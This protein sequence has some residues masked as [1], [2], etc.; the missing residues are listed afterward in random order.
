M[1]PSCWKLKKKSK[2][3]VDERTS[4]NIHGICQGRIVG[5]YIERVEHM[6]IDACGQVD[7]KHGMQR[8]LHFT[9]KFRLNKSRFS[10]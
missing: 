8:L 6:C 7:D 10:I 9:H 3:Q 5:V 1:L 4:D 2:S